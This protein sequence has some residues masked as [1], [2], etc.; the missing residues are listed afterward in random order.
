M[1]MNKLTVLLTILCCT[2]SACSKV[3]ISLTRVSATPTTVL[4]QDIEPQN[5]V[6]VSVATNAPLTQNR[7][8][9][10]NDNWTLFTTRDGLIDN[11][12]R[13][14][15][16]TSDGSMWFLTLDKGIS[17]FKQGIWTSYSKELGF[18]EETN[19]AKIFAIGSNGN[20][21]IGTRNDGIL[22][23]DGDRWTRYTTTNGLPSNKIVS[24]AVTPNGELWGSTDG[25]GVFSY[26]NGKWKTYPELG[27]LVDVQTISIDP[28][29]TVWFGTKKGHLFRFDGAT[30]LDFKIASQSAD[31]NDPIF[32]ISFAPDKSLWISA[33]HGLSHFDGKMW[34]TYNTNA[35]S[36][37]PAENLTVA[38]DNTIWFNISNFGIIHI[39]RNIDKERISFWK[40]DDP[41][42]QRFSFQ[43]GFPSLVKAIALDQNNMAWFGT[44]ANGIW[45][46]D[47][48]NWSNYFSG[49]S[50]LNQ[51][52][53]TVWD[54][55]IDS[56]GV[57]W[58][59]TSNGVLSYKYQK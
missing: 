10:P 21:W 2:A 14:I 35:E 12:V 28:E 33:R 3:P 6:M 57:V 58:F 13:A 59:A 18:S 23:F 49:Y 29:G 17:R 36:S 25:D 27:G 52:Y 43:D 51:G 5:K 30:W 8:E 47:G 32:S 40:D 42:I 19:D 31:D 9:L 44:V 24:L 45:E 55:K 20:L 34:T 26:L 15:A 1:I 41:N 37:Y 53:L 7:L 56:L 38:S 11:D 39:L 46:Y 16:N 4:S 22:Y 54:V 50:T 48:K